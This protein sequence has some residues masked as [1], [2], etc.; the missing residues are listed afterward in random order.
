[1]LYLLAFAV[2]YGLA[3]VYKQRFSALRCA[4]LLCRTGNR[5]VL[6][7]PRLW[8]LLFLLLVMLPPLLLSALREGVGTDYYYTYTP[9]FLDILN[10]ER[11]YYEIGFYWFN[12]LVG[13]FTHNPQ[14]IFVLTS[15]LFCGFVYAAFEQEGEDLPFCVLLLLVSG[16]YFISL[17]NLRQA[18]A[19]AVILYAYKYVRCKQWWR[20]AL[21]AAVMATVH[22]SMLL[23]LP[24]LA[25]FILA[26]Y[27][28]NEKILTVIAIG[29][30]AGILLINVAPSLLTFILPERLAYYIEYAIY[31]Q[32][33][34]GFI[35]TV[36]NVV[37]LAFLLFTRYRSGNKEL[38]VFVLVQLLAVDVCLLDSLI[39]AAYRILR[40]LTFWQ[41]LAIPK[42]AACFAAKD[43]RVVKLLILAGL[44]ALCVYSIVILGDEEVLPYRSIFHH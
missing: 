1:M 8:S 20:F 21:V 28:A 30:T 14:W 36:V 27:V 15:L 2:S 11:T 22:K 23:F 43:R 17:N 41:L 33:T 3:L 44:G 40:I 32:P 16:E 34:I 29:S 38:D 7:K 18:V 6:H 9:R 26:D 10:G 19:A 4:P 31:T 37:I 39:P 24:L 42:A 25:L 12:R 5:L 13:M 35:R